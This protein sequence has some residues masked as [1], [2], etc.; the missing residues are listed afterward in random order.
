MC[1]RDSI[2]IAPPIGASRDT[3]LRPRRPPRM[4]CP[5]RLRRYIV[6]S[7]SGL[8][9][10]WT[11]SNVCCGFLDAGWRKWCRSSPNCQQQLPSNATLY[12][13]NSLRLAT[14]QQQLG[15]LSCLPKLRALRGVLCQAQKFAYPY[16]GSAVKGDGNFKIA[17]R[18]KRHGHASL[19]QPIKQLCAQ[20]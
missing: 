8:R 19:F 18:I 7:A 1:I 4:E 11:T 15:V 9:F 20:F 3:M 16:S 10:C 12:A 2:Y 13:S 6:T 17:S 5:F 14:S